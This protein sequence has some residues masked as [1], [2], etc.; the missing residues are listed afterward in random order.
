MF[1]ALH[2]V[3]AGCEDILAKPVPACRQVN[4]YFKAGGAG[5]NAFKE[6]PSAEALAP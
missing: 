1:P 3:G 6:R 4:Y 2:P 5:M